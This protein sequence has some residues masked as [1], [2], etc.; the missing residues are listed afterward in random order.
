V[1]GIRPQFVCW[2]RPDWSHVLF[3]ES[4]ELRRIHIETLVEE[5]LFTLPAHLV[6]SP[7][8]CSEAGLIAFGYL[9]AELQQR[10]LACDVEDIED[11]LQAGC[12]FTVLDFATGEVVA[13]VDTPFWPNH[14]AASPD[15][16][17]VLY[18]HEGSWRRQRMHLLNLRTLE[19]A[20]LRPQSDG[21]AIGHE[22]W[23]DADSVGYHG[24]VY[25]ESVL[26]TVD[27]RT[28]VGQETRSG[29]PERYAGHCHASPDGRWIVTDG[30]ATPDIISIASAQDDTL[31]FRAICRHNWPRHLDQRF[32]PHPH[33]NPCGVITFTGCV[34]SDDGL[35]VRSCVGIAGAAAE[36]TDEAHWRHGPPAPPS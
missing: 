35:G 23:M 28:G 31:C 1:N 25:G 16:L 24:H 32:H 5:A 13:S 33:W 12:G 30:E 9:P 27:V 36:P 2:S 11:E 14:V 19:S 21:A 8:H 3:W 18:C 4:N 15:G 34:R 6:P 20:P 22:F 26:G 17:R 7:P 10:M 29:H